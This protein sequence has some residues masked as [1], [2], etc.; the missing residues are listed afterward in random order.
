MVDVKSVLAETP[1]H[2]GVAFEG[3]YE[4]IEILST[5]DF[6]YY[7][8]MNDDGKFVHVVD[9][10][11]TVKPFRAYLVK[12]GSVSLSNVFDI[13]WGDDTTGLNDVRS[14]VTEVRSDVFFDLQGRQITNPTKGIYIQNGKKVVIK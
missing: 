10:P 11:V 13:D 3:T 8:F 5:S 12:A 7:C 2:D 14:K 4:Q 1:F 9:Q 6:Q